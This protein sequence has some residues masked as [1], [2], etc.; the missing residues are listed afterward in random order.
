L[1]RILDSI[2]K[3]HRRGACF[4]LA[5][6]MRLKGIHLSLEGSA[7]RENQEIHQKLFQRR[8][9][10][11]L[12]LYGL[13]FVME[14]LERGEIPGPSQKFPEWVSDDEYQARS[15]RA[16]GMINNWC[17]GLLHVPATHTR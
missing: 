4:I 5:M 17:R 8:E 7:T 14:V 11:F 13:L 2:R 15:D 3:H 6:A 16:R 1:G 10:I 12:S 9:P